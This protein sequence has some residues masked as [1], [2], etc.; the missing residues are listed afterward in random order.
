MNDKRLHNPPGAYVPWVRPTNL[1]KECEL[2]FTDHTPAVSG[3]YAISYSPTD[4]LVPVVGA[5]P[6]RYATWLRPHDQA[7]YSGALAP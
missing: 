2:F 4:C 1:R 3:R 5:S 7:I 6:V